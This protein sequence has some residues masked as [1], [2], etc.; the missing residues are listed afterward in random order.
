MHAPVHVHIN[1]SCT[2][3]IIYPYLSQ[4]RSQE[5]GQTRALL[6][7]FGAI[8]GRK[9]VAYID[10]SLQFLKNYSLVNVP[11]LCLENT[12][13]LTTFLR[14]AQKLFTFRLIYIPFIRTKT[15]FKL[16][17]M[18]Y[19]HKK[20]LLY[21]ASKQYKYKLSTLPSLNQ[22]CKCCQSKCFDLSTRPVYVSIIH[23]FC[24]STLSG[25]VIYKFTRYAIT[26]FSD[27]IIRLINITL[28]ILTI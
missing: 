27:N 18:Q 22:R 8:T 14:E 26:E 10:G 21:T 16:H 9:I 17:A 3:F 15:D 11:Q 28:R 12:T 25:R 13:F 24:N 6:M 7:E 19:K 5:F 23:F 2:F 4:A 1:N 20:Q